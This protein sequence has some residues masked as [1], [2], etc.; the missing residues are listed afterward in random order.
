MRGKLLA[1][2]A[3]AAALVYAAPASATNL[4]T[5]GGF[6]AGDLSGWTLTGNT[7]FSGVD[8]S[9][10]H[11]GNF[12]GY[13]GQVGSTGTLSQTL[14]TVAGQ[15][16]TISFWLED[17]GGTPS[18]FDASFGGNELL[19][20]S[21]PDAFDY[22]L[23]SYSLTASSAST[24]LSFT[25]RQDPAYFHLDDVSVSP[26]GVPEPATW[27]MMMLGLG[28]AGLALRHRKGRAPAIA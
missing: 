13:F 26:A 17:D 28:A 24:L 27:A 14:S 1:V 5:N 21:N 25:F 18:S 8:T 2:S 10:V 7:S 22:T 6:E 15:T 11:S 19:A 4:V 23:Y 12:A 3:I 9:T 16:Y 20:L